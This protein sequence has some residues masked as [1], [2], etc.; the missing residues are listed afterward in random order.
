MNEFEE[1]EVLE[2][3]D[4]WDEEEEHK[5]ELYAR[6]DAIPKILPAP[7]PDPWRIIDRA[8]AQQP[9]H[10]VQ[11]AGKSGPAV[12]YEDARQLAAIFHGQGLRGITITCYATKHVESFRLRAAEKLA[13]WR[14]R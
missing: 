13:Y 1:L 12:S 10:Y 3:L 9:T 11:T 14:P 5:Q 2:M 4:A 8:M 6:L 7:G